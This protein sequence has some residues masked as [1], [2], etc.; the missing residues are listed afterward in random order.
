MILPSF[1]DVFDKF[2]AHEV[3]RK[4]EKNVFFSKEIKVLS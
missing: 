4:T 3:S 1:T 2:R